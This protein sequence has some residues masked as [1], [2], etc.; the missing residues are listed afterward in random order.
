MKHYLA[1]LLARVA[2]AMLFL[3]TTTVVRADL[4]QQRKAL[5]ELQAAKKAADPMPLLESAK[6]RITKANK[7]NKGGD[8]E[9]VIAKINEAIEQLEAG[10]RS[11]M[12]QKINAA[13]A[14]LHQGKDKSKRPK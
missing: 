14:N 6:N 12:E 13:I 8:K 9:D 1:C 10:N 4:P 3:G 2:C 11:K 7:G 5:D